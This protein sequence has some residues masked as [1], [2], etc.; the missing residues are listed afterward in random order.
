MRAE[1]ITTLVH[2]VFGRSF[3]TEI[4][5]GWVSM[6]CP[7]SPWTHTNGR[8]NNPSAGISIHPTN[9]SI[10]NCLAGYT[11]VVTREGLKTIASLAGT[12]P[13]LLMPDG[14]WL[15]APV[16]GF[17]TQPL[18]CITLSRNGRT[19]QVYATAMHRWFYRSSYGSFK[20]CTTDE[21]REGM[22][23]QSA[24]PVKRT[25]WALDPR[26]VL[27]GLV[28]GDG[29][30]A[31]HAPSHG[32]LCLFGECRNLATELGRT[33]GLNVTIGLETENG[34][35]YNAVSGQIGHLKELPTTS[36]PAY[37]LGFLSGLIAADGCVDERG[38]VSIANASLNL[39]SKVQD[40]AVRLGIAVFGVSGQERMGLGRVVSS[41]Y[42]LRFVS[43]T[44]D[45]SMFTLPTQRSRFSLRNVGYERLNWTV[46]SVEVTERVEAV[47]CAEVPGYHAFVLD[48][49]IVTGNCFT[50]GNKSPISGLIARYARFTGDDFSDLIGELEDEEYLGPT[51]LPSWDDAK[52]HERVELP[53]LDPDIYLGLY[54]SAA[55]HPYLL[56]RGVGAEAAELL[57]LLVDP[58]DPRDGEERILFPVHGID[59]TLHG[60]SGRATNKAAKLKVR[61]YYGLPKA[62]C[63]LGAH[64]INPAVHR[65][66]LA[67][68]GLV[69]Y[70]RTWHNGFPAV[71]LMHS[72]VTPDQARLLRTLGLP[73]YGFTDDDDAGRKGSA[74]LGEALRGYQPALK[75]RYPKVWIVD[76][77]E[78]GGG[79]WLKDPGELEPEEVQAMIDDARLL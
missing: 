25:D 9:T 16:R 60:F 24:K 35:P 20:E 34:T 5:G 40:I 58:S 73:T 45:A 36:D 17:G 62:R 77:E 68:E 12:E 32:R 15:K 23:L 3:R 7:L 67:V 39:I 13:E 48:G 33:H 46:S 10:F 51:S 79:H 65:Y 27:H 75:V 18:R 38:N 26:G 37:L 55:D 1:D 70:A 72:S 11:K 56:N 2:D 63:L 53:A 47:Y 54:E 22:R 28:F 31:T 29:T 61:D 76:P 41:I 59:G 69:D 14:T 66:V 6:C 21:L 64:L 52:S 8:D 57:G 19:K 30:R 43:S 49:N 4:V 78:D 74:A 71:A 42:T 44:L 50:C